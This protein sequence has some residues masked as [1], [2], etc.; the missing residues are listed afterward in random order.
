MK[1]FL[2]VFLLG[3]VLLITVQ[4]SET[5]DS[6]SVQ[7]PKKIE[8]VDIT[9]NETIINEIWQKKTFNQCASESTIKAQ[10]QFS[11]SNSQEYQEELELSSGL[12]GNIS[13]PSLVEATLEGS[14]RQHFTSSTGS[15]KEYRES[16]EIQVPPLTRQEYTILWRETR[17]EGTVKYIDNGVAKTATYSYRVGLELI[18][19]NVRALSCTET[20]TPTPSPP[21][22]TSTLPPTTASVTAA[23]VPPATITDTPVAASTP[24]I[25]LASLKITV[26]NV[27]HLTELFALKGHTGDVK[28][29]AWS[30]DS[31]RLVSGS[32]D[33]KVRVWD[34]SNRNELF[35]LEGHRGDVNSV[36]WSPDGKLLASGGDDNKVRVW[37]AVNG[38]ELYEFVGHGGNINSVAWSPDSKL[39]ASG[40]NDFKTLIW[41]A[42]THVQ[43]NVLEGHSDSV[44]SVAWSPDG[45]MLA[46]GGSDNRVL[47]WEVATG[48]QLRVWKLKGFLGI[49]YSVAWSPDGT[50]LA[51]GGSDNKL[52]VLDAATGDELHVLEGPKNDVNSVA[53]SPDS[54]M[55]A[56]FDSN[57]DLWVWNASTGD[58]LFM[59]G[60]G[61]FALVRSVAWSPDGTLLAL[62]S[63][64]NMVHVFGIR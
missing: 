14:I 35:I 2:S 58:K 12:D 9:E 50:R 21:T 19:T 30:P 16:V 6:G 11:Q 51:S 59:Q 4:C 38:K 25:H 10:I 5:S 8:V 49:V 54:T 55:L 33:N 26:D 40:S 31:A 29:V 7:L 34:I 44:N 3:C 39:L 42:A 45:T 47:M 23:M 63:G 28:S 46:S 62:G 17:R 15:E 57:G 37:D 13:I 18:S 22:M 27:A 36:A 41:D 32:N 56:A 52:R 61:D 24:S 64:D 53:W 48:N 43:L 60:M 1:R 20:D